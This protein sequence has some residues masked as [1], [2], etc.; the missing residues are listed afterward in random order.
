MNLFQVYSLLDM[1]PVKAQGAYLWDK[2]GVEY[3]D[4]YGGHA[5]ANGYSLRSPDY[6]EPDYCY[7]LPVL[8]RLCCLLSDAFGIG[9]VDGIPLLESKKSIVRI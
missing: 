2:Q 8:C 6:Y 3:L 4:F 7:V 1:E 5:E 9:T